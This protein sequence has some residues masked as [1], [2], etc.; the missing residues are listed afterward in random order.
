MS[1][2]LLVLDALRA[3]VESLSHSA[4]TPSPAASPDKPSSDAIYW[5]REHRFPLPPRWIVFMVLLPLAELLH[6]N[7]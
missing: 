1:D 5:D 3:G 4:V 2:R 7:L 6:P